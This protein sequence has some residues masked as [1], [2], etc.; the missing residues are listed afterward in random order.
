MEKGNKEA[1][2]GQQ[3]KRQ[4][5]GWRTVRENAGKGRLLNINIFPCSPSHSHP[6]SHPSYT[7]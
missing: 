7:I 5:R 3:R 2:F 1:E 4:N 6:H